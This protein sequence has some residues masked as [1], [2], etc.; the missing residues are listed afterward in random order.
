MFIYTSTSAMSLALSTDDASTR[1]EIFSR[2]SDTITI[3]GHDL[4]H[5]EKKSLIKKLLL[6]SAM[7]DNVNE[8][9]ELQDS[10]SKSKNI[11]EAESTINKMIEKY[12][13][14]VGKMEDKIPG[15]RKKG[16]KYLK[17]PTGYRILNHIATGLTS[18]IAG[19]I[20]GLPMLKLLPNKAD[21]AIAQSYNDYLSRKN[22]EEYYCDLF[23][24][25]YNLPLSFTYGFKNKEFVANDFPEDK[26]KYLADLEKQLYE[27]AMSQYPTI[28]ERN[29]TAY[30]IAKTILSGQEKISDECRKYCEWIVN[31]YSKI[32]NTNISSNFNNHTFDPK[33]A[34]DLDKHIQELI[35]NN[36]ITVTESYYSR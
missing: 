3:D 24:G 34:E 33:E 27:F 8:M 25:V 15:A 35:L 26:L 10:M 13:K 2:F 28:N 11:S 19:G 21:A 6:I 7:S 12:E 18:T 9:K 29:Y 14:M 22:K 20:I 16:N 23:A 1:R 17:H 32:D 4:N 36:N 31:N 30:H 5:L